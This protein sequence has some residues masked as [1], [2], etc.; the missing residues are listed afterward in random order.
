MAETKL[1]LWKSH[2]GKGHISC[3]FDKFQ[4]L[5]DALEKAVGVDFKGVQM[6]KDNVGREA[7][8]DTPITRQKKLN[9]S[10]EQFNRFS[11]RCNISNK[12]SV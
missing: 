11:F 8:G 6:P 12:K 5:F 4:E 3:Q 1:M 2:Y 9:T 10:K 7:P